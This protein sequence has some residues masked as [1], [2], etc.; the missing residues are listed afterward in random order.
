MPL[1]LSTTRPL[2]LFNPISST[3]PFTPYIFSLK[4]IIPSTL[5]VLP[6]RFIINL[7]PLRRPRHRSTSLTHPI[8]TEI[9]LQQWYRYV[10]ITVILPRLTR[11]VSLLPRTHE[12]DIGIRFRARKSKRAIIRARKFK[13][14]WKQ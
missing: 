5:A 7:S 1:Q 4:H 12:D 3:L 6:S 11:N 8:K 2:H 9:L 10:P 14:L 13:T